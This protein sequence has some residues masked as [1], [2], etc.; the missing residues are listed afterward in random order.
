MSHQIQT[1]GALDRD[2]PAGQYPWQ[3]NVVAQDMCHKASG[4][5]L[6]SSKQGY[7]TVNVYLQDVNDNPPLFDALLVNATVA[8][9]SAIGKYSFT[10]L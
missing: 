1:T 2:Y 8:E 6:P 10:L 4:L 5:C 7:A 9:N 3:F